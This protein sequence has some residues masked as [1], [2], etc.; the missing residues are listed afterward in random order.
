[1]DG[2]LVD[3]LDYHVSA[4]QQLGRELGHSLEADRIRRLFGQRNREIITGLMRGCVPAEDIPKIAARKEAIYR[5][6]IASE[7]RP[8]PGLV[9]FL[10]ALQQQKVRNAVATSACLENANLVLDGLRIRSYFDAVLTG[11]DVTRSKPDPEIFLLAAGRLGVAPGHCVVFEDSVAGIDAA[12]RA[13]CLCIALATTHS[14][15]ELR[16]LQ[17]D[18]VI[19]DFTAM[20]VG[21]LRGLR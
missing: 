3:N 7:L 21:E 16:S 20:T 15:D 5:F 4:W 8:V 6:C 12:Q 17:P 2:V 14:A 10:R 9:V 13:G 18:R 19:P 1:M 11:A